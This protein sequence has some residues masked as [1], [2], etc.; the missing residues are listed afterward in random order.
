MKNKFPKIKGKILFNEPLNKHTSFKVG[1]KCSVWAEPSDEKEL[2]KILKFAAL[3]RKKIFL[4]GSGSNVLVRDKGFKGIVI[5]LRNN[6]FRKINFKKTSV[7]VGAGASLGNLINISCKRGLAGLE[8]MIGIPGTLG[9]SIFMN[10]GY[11]EN[12]S[13]LVQNIKTVHKKTGKIRVLKKKTLKFGYRRSNLNDFIILEIT[14]RLKKENKTL[15]LKRKKMFIKDKIAKQPMNALS[16]GCVFKNPKG[17]ISAGQY[18]DMAGLKGKRVGKAQISKRHANFIVNKK[19]ATS[20]DIL[21]LMDIVKK[22]VKT[23]FNK[24]LVPEIKVI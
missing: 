13:C 17:G 8:G 23:R 24:T 19:G 7:K 5:H 21:C 3:T 12:I 1:G 22:R 4:M 18:I 9:G 10:A 14:L 20:K 16:A 2:Q 6:N 15:L 11:K